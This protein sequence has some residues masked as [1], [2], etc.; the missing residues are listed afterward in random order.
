MRYGSLF[1]GIGGLE[2]PTIRPEFFCE[3]DEAAQRVLR[4]TYRDI[5][6]WDDVTRLQTARVDCVAGGWPCQDLT[7][8][9]RMRGIHA[10]RSGLF[11]EMVRYAKRCQAKTV[12]GEN[13][14]NLLRIRGGRDFRVVIDTLVEA[15]FRWVS[16]RTL[17][18]R[19]FGLPQSRRRVIIVASVEKDTAWSLHRTIVASDRVRGSRTPDPGANGNRA[20]GFY[21][22]GG[23]GRS[24][25]LA[26][27][28]VPP[29]KVGS[30]TSKGTSP[31]AVF[32]AGEVRK[33]S[34]A[35][36]LQLQGFKASAAFDGHIEGD[37]FRMAG[38]AVPRPLG[39][40]ALQCA[41]WGKS[42]DICPRDASSI[43]A[44]GVFASGRMWR[45]DHELRFSFAPLG[46]F[47]DHGCR[48]LSPQASAGLLTRVIRS[49]RRIPVGMF[50]A[51]Y[52]RS[53]TR[54]S[55]I[56]TTINSFD[57][58]DR[59]LD[60]GAYRDWLMSEGDEPELDRETA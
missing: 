15:G 38:N 21:W 51:L 13:V 11:F 48:V 9:G 27:G 39:Q 40:F 46:S 4:A 34:A 45:L 41:T 52:T 6:I 53:R 55:L 19:E 32:S 8:A 30:S 47:L 58:L 36:G 16:W 33:L 42:V 56:G 18:A 2:H 24:L 1:S 12:I 22:T 35:A 28:V 59:Q 60:A 31:V 3:R 44:S 57:V 7:V 50:D 49:S 25:C 17:D 37:V 43:P 14:P 54:T 20:Y 29:L 26:E 5:P 23:L 10:E